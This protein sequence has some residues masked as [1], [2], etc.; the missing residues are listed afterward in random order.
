MTDT[1]TAAEANRLFYRE[2]A[3]TYDA[4]EVCLRDSRRQDELRG[5]VA[6]ALSRIDG[7]VSVLDACGGTGNIGLAL[8][9]YGIVPVVVD[10]SPEMTAIWRA[11]AERLGYSPE[12]HH[13]P[14]EDFLRDDGRS[15][16]LITFSSALHHLADYAEVVL[17]AAARLEPGGLILTIFDT[18][19]ATPGLRLLR[20]AD[21]VGWLLITSPLRFLR[22]L[23]GAVR[24]ASRADG[25]ERHVGRLAEV[26]AYAGIDDWALVGLLADHGL[27]VVVHKRV[28]EARLGLVRFILRCADWPSEFSLLV[29]R[30]TQDKLR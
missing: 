24:R 2:D 10:V 18:T 23:A 11:K 27:D 29:R 7:R 9:P 4:T 28:Y 25:E 8:H 21:F 19:Q 1:L 17:A 15:W 20:K 14:I 3:E 22:L 12:I 26:H 30:P 5:A 13:A 6:A 16:K